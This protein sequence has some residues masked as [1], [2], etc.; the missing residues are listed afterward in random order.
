MAKYTAYVPSYNNSITIGSALWCL[1][2]Q[3]LPPSEL[4]QVDDC[5]TDAS[6][7][8]AVELGIPVVRLGMNSGRGAVRAKGMVLAKQEFVLCCDSTNYLQID[9]ADHALKWFAD[10]M[11]AAVF[12]RLWQEKPQTLSDR[13]RGR[14]LFKLQ[15]QRPLQ[16]DALLSTYGCVLR[17]SAVLSVGNFNWN[18]RHSEDADLGHRLLSAGFKVIFDPSLHVISAVSN[19][20]LEVLDRYWRWHAGPYEDVT[21]HGYLKLIWYAITVLAL[22]DIRDG[23]WYSVPVSLLCPHYQFWK[24]LQRKIFRKVQT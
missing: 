6:C 21:L 23:D 3:S 17:R 16:H 10:P 24:S 20:T 18:L 15:A 19:S 5:S 22:R 2:N 11:V 8:A 14:H 7:E 1:Q 9:F 4:F 13:W 12:G